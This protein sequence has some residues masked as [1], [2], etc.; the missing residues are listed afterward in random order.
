MLKELPERYTVANLEDV[1]EILD[2]QRVPINSRERAERKGNIPYYGATGQVGWIDD[3]LFDEELILLGEDGAPFLDPYKQ[4]AYLI[5]G[6]SWVNNHAHVLR[7]MGG[8][9]NAYIKYYL[10]IVDYQQ[11][12]TGTTRLKLNQRAMRGIP[13]PIAPENEQKRIV[14]EIEKQFSRLDEAVENLQR[15]KVNLKRYKAS[16]LKAAVEGKLTEQWRAENPDV[17]PASQLLERILKERRKKWEENELAKMKAKGKVPKDDRWKKKYKE[18]NTIPIDLPTV[19]V[20]SKWKWVTVDQIGTIGEQTVMTGPFGS[21]LGKADFQSS[22]VPV[23]TIGCLKEEGVS[24]Q[25]ASYI[26]E[27]KAMELSRYRLREGDL[28]FSRM[29]AVGRAGVVTKEFSGA[30]FNYHIMR[31][32]LANEAISSGYFVSFVRGSKMVLDYVREVNHGATRDGIN[33]EQLMNLPVALPPTKEQE[34]IVLEIDKRLSV[35]LEIENQLNTDFA[36]ATRLRQ[37]I[38]KKTFSGQLIS[39]KNEYDDKPAAEP[40][41]AAEASAT[42]G[43]KT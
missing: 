40:L 41:L 20:P 14:A 22:G 39:S 26:S 38:L 37:S 17:E 35:I 16:V 15:V 4:K 23:I 24:L 1:V 7:S 21:N 31:L 42:Y 8:I 33:T 34:Q 29:A 32:R 18:P 28:L 19:D 27:E 11:F 30:I 36:R 13:V 12:V 9:P 6:K 25:K 43:N 10:D 3:W 2:S 5:K